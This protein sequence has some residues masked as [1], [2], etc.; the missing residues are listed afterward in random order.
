M[1]VFESVLELSD[2]LCGIRQQHSISVDG[3]VEP[4]TQILHA[5]VVLHFVGLHVREK[6]AV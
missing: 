6:L 2:V 4:L 3:I 5:I 1:V